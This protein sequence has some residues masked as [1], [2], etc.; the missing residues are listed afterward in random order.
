M[1]TIDHIDPAHTT[2]TLTDAY[3]WTTAYGY[4]Q[5][6]RGEN[7]AVSYMFG[8]KES[9][10]SGYTV[11]SGLESLI[12]VVKR[13]Q[14]NGLSDEDMAWLRAQKRPSG[15][16][17]Y[18][19]DFLDYMKNR[20]FRL[21]ISAAR[22]GDLIFPQEAA[23]RVEGTVIECKL[24]ESVA[25]CLGNGSSGYASHGARVR[26]ALNTELENGAPRG[27]ASVQGLRRGPDIGAALAASRNLEIGGYTSSSTGTAARDYG[28]AFVGTM[29][30]AWVQTHKAELGDITLGDLYRMEDEGRTGELRQARVSDAFRSF[31]MAHPE[32]GILLLDTYD[33]MQGLEHA[34]TVFREMRDLGMKFS[35]GVRF[36]SGDLVKYSR[37]A[38]R[39]FAEEGFF[40]GLDRVQVD[41][42]T[43]DE[44]LLESDR[45]SLFCAAAD[46]LDEFK[47]L[48][49]RRR[50]AFFR[51]WGFGTAGSHVP[52]PGMVYKA[53][54]IYMDVLDGKSI[55][56]AEQD[57]TPVMKVSLHVPEKSSNPGL[58]NSR[59][60]YDAA[61]RLSHV[62]I[63][64]ER[65]G[66]DPQARG[67]NTRN[68]KD[69]RTLP[70]GVETRTLL[71][72][73][74]DRDGHYVYQ[75]PA[76]KE[77]FP[78]SGDRV[79]NLSAL[80]AEV[81]RQLDT[82][83]DGARRIVRPREDEVKN[84]LFAAYEAALKAGHE[85]LSVNIADFEKAL[86]PQPEH[87][88]VYLDWNLY[89][90]RLACQQRHVRHIG[91]GG[92][93]TP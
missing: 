39:R 78:G 46:D 38:M 1:G 23:L 80:S 90:Q 43:D 60:V 59:R 50:G 11:A 84:R 29:D 15:Q 13:W 32:N 37:V 63:F 17:R 57:M 28:Q 75:E 86:P 42:M 73:V 41:A 54:A 3:H 72:P 7:P 58:I 79:T 47:A 81:A 14:E 87:V 56:E 26:D 31:V 89:E 6:G 68:L 61:G 19:D 49:M 27:Q 35:Y 9:K 21:K 55:E 92:T 4:W 18:S 70:A 85:N 64:D 74:F 53:A 30:H 5:E 33:P 44:L 12:A 24:L 25:L 83:P 48:D 40:D 62:V 66:I 65:L 51:F 10:G 71:A 93:L 76:R 82:L 20:K 45:C 52:T 22:E 2:P 8:R 69:V 34:V 91:G 88:P 77:K 67:V 16:P 36:D